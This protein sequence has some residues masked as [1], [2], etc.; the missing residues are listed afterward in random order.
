MENSTQPKT[1]QEKLELMRVGY[2][3]DLSL[4]YGNLKIPIRI[5]TATQEN[6]YVTQGKIDAKKKMI[7]V[8]DEHDKQLIES[9]EVIKSILHNATTIDNVPFL[10]LE[11]LEQLTS[12]ELV[13]LYDEYYEILS[14]VSPEFEKIS[15]A[16]IEQIILEVKK[17]PI[18]LKGLSTRQRRAIGNYFLE[19]VLPQ[20]K[21]LGS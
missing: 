19:T 20:V 18:A 9:R 17:N 11:L 7:G 21:E 14:Q 1:N 3:A 4:K 2:K 8:V 15:F 10:T 16:E 13:A 5:L 6:E 12:A